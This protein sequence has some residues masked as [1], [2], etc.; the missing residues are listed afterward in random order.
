[1]TWV[2]RVV[3]PIAMSVRPPRLPKHPA[4]WIEFA[5]AIQRMFPG[6]LPYANA[7]EYLLVLA[8]G[9]RGSGP[10]P[11]LPWHSAAASGRL[12]RDADAL[13]LDGRACIWLERMLPAARVRIWIS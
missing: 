9:R 13:A 8:A 11:V 6:E 12:P 10:L 2:G 3:G 4:E 7:A 5:H 1:M